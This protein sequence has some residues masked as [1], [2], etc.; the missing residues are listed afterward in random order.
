MRR[1]RWALALAVLGGAAWALAARART[2]RARTQPLP[3][4]ATP[5]STPLPPTAAEYSRRQDVFLATLAHELRNPLAPIRNAAQVL[6][7]HHHDPQQVAWAG[8]VI[9]RQV[10]TLGRLLDGLLE[11]SRVTL[12]TLALQREAVVLRGVVDAAVELARPVLD[13]H[14]QSLDITG[15]A[16]GL[17]LDADPLRLA[18]VLGILLDNAARYSA[19]GGHVTLTAQRLGPEVEVRVQDTGVGLTAEELDRVFEMFVQLRAHA[20]GGL[21]MGLALARGLVGLHG[22]RLEAHSPGPGQGSVFSVR[23]PLGPTAPPVAPPRPR[24]QAATGSGLLQ[25]MVVDDNHDGA[26]S[27]AALLA[28]AGHHVAVAY[29]GLQAL[30]LA[31][32][33]PPDVALIDIGMPLIDG[34]ELARRI[35]SQPWGTRPYLIAATGWGQPEDRQRT[36]ASGFDRHLVKPIDPE[37]I[38]QML[39]DRAVRTGP[40]QRPSAGA[41]VPETGSGTGS[42]TGSDTGSEMGP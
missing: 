6:R 3:L 39:A 14:G 33:Q 20:E 31:A 42:D 7:T 40:A 28:Q 30:E 32:V 19:P 8:E 26:D 15:D 2:G 37:Q 13:Q 21:G 17:T 35:R 22:G 29:D 34:C 5:G 24:V 38:L 11:V 4:P 36:R 10:A 25:V 16:L 18:Q 41:P 27:L 23:L 9:D 12:G 1:P